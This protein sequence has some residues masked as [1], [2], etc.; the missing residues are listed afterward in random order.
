MS[1]SFGAP[2]SA[3]AS[4]GLAGGFSFG[5]NKPAASG[6]GLTATTQSSGFFGST[7]TTSAPAFGATSAFG[8]STT[9]AFGANT[10]ST[11]GAAA[12]AFG[13]T[14]AFGASTTPAFGATAAPAFGATSTAPAFG[15]TTATP[16]FGATSAAPAFGAT[17]TPAFG[18]TSQPAFG[19]T[20]APAFGQSTAPSFGA[21]LGTGSLNFGTGTST[22]SSGLSF[23]NP[24]TTASTGLGGLGGFGFGAASTQNSFGFGTSA[25]NTTNSLF[26]IIMYPNH[27]F[28][29][30]G[31][32]I[33]ITQTFQTM[34]SYLGS[35]YCDEP[36]RDYEPE[37]SYQIKFAKRDTYHTITPS[38]VTPS[39]G[40]GGLSQSGIGAANTTT[41]DG[42]SEPPKQNKLPN[43]ILTNVENFKEFVKKQ[44]SISSDV[45][46]VSS[47]PLHKVSVE[48]EA[49]LRQALTLSSGVCRGRCAAG[50]LRA[51]AA[52][53]LAHAETCARDALG[54]GVC[55]GRCA[56]G[57][58]RAA[59]AA[60]SRTRRPAPG[61]RSVSDT[62][63]HTHT[64][65]GVCRG[66]CAAGRL[67]AAAAA[68]LAHAETCARDALG[69]E[70]EGMAPPPYI[71]EVLS[72]LEQQIITFRRQMEVADKQ[73]QS[74]PK[75]LTEQELTLGIRRMHESLVALAGR[76]QAVHTQVEAQKEQ[77]L[78]LRKYV[79]KDSTDVFNSIS[80]ST[81]LDQIL[82][83][84]EGTR[85]KTKTG[86]NDSSL[87]RAVLS[88]P[89]AVLSNISQ[90]AGP[91]PFSYLGNSLSPFP[92]H[93]TSGGSWQPTPAPAPAPLA[94][95]SFAPS[96]ES[97]GFQLQK[98][99][100]K[101]GKQ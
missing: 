92:G 93:D 98:P 88:D 13:S 100:G 3:P 95:P 42:K 81:S 46:R 99:P 43:E 101:R 8:A 59:A 47:K 62:H 87:G 31:P 5:A 89:R 90:L 48:A 77:Y 7:A 79:L 39:L 60:R 74:S 16:A 29:F 63:T 65:S 61:T 80:A 25:A 66:R 4:S 9:P 36:V 64:H 35:S 76:L 50:R 2:S 20:A 55:R 33:P 53:A 75:L 14:S 12:P 84:A 49:T 67:R 83:D 73:M 38:C 96:Q 10:S 17:A 11:F 52:A 40:L 26:G 71:K 32:Y 54:D 34:P 19:A 78:N 1:F 23:G 28:P 15:A 58:L 6:F 30:E 22:A 97:S 27:S 37:N 86:M 70:L 24:A 69:T 44:K 94:A 82:R 51:A 18:A 68:A 72:E 56:A 57:R 85:K 45:M 91:T 41:G 21:G